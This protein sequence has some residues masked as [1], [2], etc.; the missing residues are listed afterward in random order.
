VHTVGFKPENIIL[1]GDSAGGNLALALARYLAEYAPELKPGA[2]LLLSPW[3]DLSVLGQ[4]TESML[5]DCDY[6]PRDTSYPVS[7]FAGLFGIQ[8]ADTSR[9]MSPARAGHF[10][11]FPKAYIISGGAEIF[12][13]QI[14]E[15]AAKMQKDS[16]PENVKY[17]EMVEAVHDTLVM[18]RFEPETRMAFE[19]M[20]KW[21]REL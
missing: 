2:M 11:G 9:W 3:C 20:A 17:V 7:G 13:D 1:A 14:R 18:L 19:G 6:I 12:R 4:D 15:L 10:E 8:I 21:I 16:G 5:F